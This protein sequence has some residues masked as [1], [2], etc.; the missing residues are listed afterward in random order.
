MPTDIKLKNSVTATNAPTSLQQGEV[1]INITDKKVWVGNAATTPVLLL[2]SGADGTF[3]N[4]TVSGVAS[5]ADGT[6]SLPS[7][8]NIGDTNTGI[9][10]PAADTIAFTEGGVESMRIDSS[11]NV[12]IG[13]S[14][15]SQR[16]DVNGGRSYFAANNE[17][18]SI[19]VRYNGST[20][21]AF[22]GS[23]SADTLTISSWGGTERVRVDSSG[24]V[25]IGTSSP[26]SFGKFA[27]VGGV[28]AFANSQPD[29]TLG[30]CVAFQLSGFNT[31]FQ[32][33]IRSS[34]SSSIASSVLAFNLC[35]G[36]N[37]NTEVMRIQ[38]GNL[39]IGTSSPSYKL[40]VVGS[41]TGA[42]ARIES[43]STGNAQLSFVN[44]STSGTG[45]VVGLLNDTSGNALIYHQDAK[46]IAFWTSATER[47]RI[48]S[49]G[50]VGIATSSPASALEIYRAVSTTGSLTDASLM[51]STSATT[52][53]KVSIGFGL[54]G[55]VANTCAAVI[56]Y[57]VTNGA[58]AGLGDIY[59]ST[60]SVTS[61]TA[62]TERMR[63]DSSGNLLLGTTSNY[64]G[65]RLDLRGSVDGTFLVT[66]TNQM[67]TGNPFGL[68]IYYSSLIPNN[69]TSNFI[70]VSDSTTL[71]FQVRS[72]GGIANYQANDV[73][74]S[75]A[76]EKTNVE[77]A[78]SYLDK[79][80]AIPVKTFNYIDQNR[81]EDDGLTLGVIAQDV[82]A[83]APELVME[84]N[85]AGKDQ[86]EKMRLSIYQTDLQYAL[87]KCI[88]E[89][90]ALIE[91]LTT[92]LNALEGK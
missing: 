35:N 80:C 51:L 2:G 27:V 33:L 66:F 57:D 17:P 25:G 42:Q 69:T 49:G 34:V 81:E 55:G 71:R 19:G 22:I 78:S 1:A 76:R 72:N 83:V 59:F 75:D 9:F 77:L 10:F 54:G 90:Q 56:G 32:N 20:N 21:G 87:M 8:T 47:M 24:N 26:S 40:H 43:T 63:I 50:N 65:R 31:E 84:S 36:S 61:D 41:G 3:T 12:G 92:R 23:P 91:N 30:T 44:T 85:W 13:S 73:N 64:G 11:G 46:P 16:L 45:F 29:G 68:Q 48:T 70:E 88:Q 86:P 4:L 62:P 37:S 74:L 82:Q 7:I 67:T 28:S 58:G 52:G 53:R 14:S 18:Y 60:R 89:Q 6:V 79:I 38:G 39:G 5:F 15:P